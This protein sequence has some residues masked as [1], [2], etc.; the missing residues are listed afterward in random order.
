[1]LGISHLD[2]LVL[3][4]SD[5]KKTCEFYEKVLGFEI[6]TFGQGRRAM[7]FGKQKF[8]LHQAGQELEPKALRPTPGSMD[9]CLITSL[10]LEIVVEKLKLA[11]VP[12]EAGPITR[13]GAQGPILSVYIRD[14][15]HNLIEISSY[16]E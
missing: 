11:A 12:I 5:V 16:D 2:H 3:T 8:N 7:A 10:A 14:P 13:T 4:V 1:M 6:I 9:L 15:D